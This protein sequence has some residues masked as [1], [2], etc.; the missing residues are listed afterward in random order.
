MGRL[1]ELVKQYQYIES[2]IKKLN[3]MP[4]EKNMVR[5]MECH[6]EIYFEG[7]AP[8]YCDDCAKCKVLTK[9]EFAEK[10]GYHSTPEYGGHALFD[11]KKPLISDLNALLREEL[12]KF[13]EYEG[14]VDIPIH[15]PIETIVDEYLKLQQ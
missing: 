9:E 7:D 11:F 4:V 15:V 8:V 14:T 12:I 10:W 13:V 6:K 1:S 3:N 2:L 5:C